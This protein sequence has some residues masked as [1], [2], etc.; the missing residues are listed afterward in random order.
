MTFFGS[1][2]L[3]ADLSV[4]NFCYVWWFEMGGAFFIVLV[5]TLAWSGRAKLRN[6]NA[7]FYSVVSTFVP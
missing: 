5:K 4:V 7:C 6:M 2:L 3:K 1:F